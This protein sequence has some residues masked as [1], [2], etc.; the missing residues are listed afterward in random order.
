MRVGVVTVNKLG[1]LTSQKWSRVI[2]HCFSTRWAQA[3]ESRRLI[4]ISAKWRSWA[5]QTICY[6]HGGRSPK[7][8]AVCAAG[9]PLGDQSDGRLFAPGSSPPC[10]RAVNEI[11]QKF[12]EKAL[13]PLRICLVESAE[14]KNNYYK[15]LIIIIMIIPGLHWRIHSEL[16]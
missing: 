16:C 2:N 15:L 1:N 9:R 7:I 4:H 11:L 13:Q 14:Y 3:G 5:A 12:L 6:L 8:F 10:T